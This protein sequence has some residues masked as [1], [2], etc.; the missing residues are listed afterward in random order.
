MRNAEEI[1][2]LNDAN[3][4]STRVEK[5][6]NEYVEEM[7]QKLEELIGSKTGKL[8]Y[9]EMI[10]PFIPLGTEETDA[11]NLAVEKIEE[12][13]YDVELLETTI[14]VMSYH[15]G[16]PIMVNA[17]AFSINIYLD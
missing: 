12:F 3:Y 4:D 7:S 6:A 8:N 10:I 5:L 2:A 16:E 17:P 1:M 11:A 15:D 14:Q 9:V 13:G